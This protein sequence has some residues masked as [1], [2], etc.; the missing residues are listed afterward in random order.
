MYLDTIHKNIIF[1]AFSDKKEGIFIIKEILMA[2]MQ[3]EFVLAS[4]IFLAISILMC[5]DCWV[6]FAKADVPGWT[7]LIPF[8]SIYKMN[9][10]ATGESIW[11]ILTFVPVINA[12]AML[13]I[14]FK[15]VR[16]YRNN[17][18][19]SKSAVMAI[20]TLF[21]APITLTML[22]INVYTSYIGPQPLL[23]RH[24]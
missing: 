15:F 2:T 20:A 14:L 1:L 24:D 17:L 4:M 9:Q 18:N 10:I 16:A 5:A 6:L 13:I 23:T 11:F 7:I 21:F 19:A 12:I 3:P 22:A 8:Y